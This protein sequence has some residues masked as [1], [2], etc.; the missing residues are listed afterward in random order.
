MKVCVSEA[1]D[2]F[3][4]IIKSEDGIKRYWFDQEDDKTKLVDVFKEL[5]FD[6]EYEED[7]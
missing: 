3:T 6:S 5:G 4:I 7:Y 1:C 2:G